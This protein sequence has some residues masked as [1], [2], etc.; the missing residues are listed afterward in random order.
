MITL[1]ITPSSNQLIS[2]I[3]ETIS[4]STDVP[5]SI[6]YT[7]DGTA[8]TTSSSIYLGV[9]VMPTNVGTITLNIFATNGVD[10]S[11]II[12]QTYATNLVGDRVP[13]ATVENFSAAANNRANL[14]NFGDIVPNFPPDFGRIGG[15]IVNDKTL[16]QIPDGY[17]G[18]ATNTSPGATNLPLTS[19]QIEYS[20]TDYQG[21]VGRGLGTLPANVSILPEKPIPESSNVNSPFFNPKAAVIYQDASET[22]LDP[23]VAVINRPYFQLEDLEKVRNGA[24]YM[25]TAFEGVQAYGSLVR[26]EFNPRT[27]EMTYYYFDSHAQRW[28]IS[29]QPYT[30]KDPNIN[31]FGN[32][33]SD[34]RQEGVGKVYRWIMFK[35]SRLI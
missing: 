18:T 5:A 25:N 11:N 22:P 14:G 6:F 10:S 12:T 28:I 4:A 26:T 23:N 33:I 8:P 3:P 13:R 15:I 20:E 21:K 16:P 7:L 24:Y 1:T 34:P 19:Y 27:Q 30:A 9:I 32:I 17:D 29:K 2:G 35:G 31:N